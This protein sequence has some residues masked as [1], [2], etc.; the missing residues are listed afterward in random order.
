[1]YV[2]LHVGEHFTGILAPATVP[3]RFVE[4]ALANFMLLCVKLM[5]REQM[6]EHLCKSMGV[7]LC[8]CMCV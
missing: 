8:V 4:R 5:S 6:Q 3:S 7:C 1:M 2:W